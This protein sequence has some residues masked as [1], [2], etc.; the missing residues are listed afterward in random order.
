M[1]IDTEE[2][3]QET[4]SARSLARSIS[5]SL[6]LLWPVSVD[7]NDH[8]ALVCRCNQQWACTNQNKIITLLDI[9]NESVF[10]EQKKK[11]AMLLYDSTVWKYIHAKKKK[12]QNVATTSFLCSYKHTVLFSDLFMCM[13]Q[14][15]G[16]SKLI[17]R[18]KIIISAH[19]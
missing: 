10:V 17:E 4:I 3:L 11:K 19:V 15:R 9:A 13:G 5:L 18:K 14:L 16:S 12:Q 6:M 1:T 7:C 2:Q 8:Q